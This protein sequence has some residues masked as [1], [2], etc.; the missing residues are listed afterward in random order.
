M[1][2]PEIYYLHHDVVFLAKDL[3]GKYLF[4]K[5]DGQLCGGIITET[6]AYKGMEDKACHAFGGRRTPRNEMMYARGGVAYVY[7]CYGIHPLLNVVVNQK[8]TPDAILIRAIHATHGEELMLKRTGKPQMKSQVTDGPGKV[9]KAL[10]ITL[11]DNGESF[12]NKRIWIEDRG[13]DLSK[14]EILN[15]PRIGID[16]AGEDAFLP[17]R[18]K[19]FEP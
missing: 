4:T 16:Y 18:F 5:I 15:T 11:A 13:F 7:L 8:D 19:I 14:I 17:Y 10:G 3:I 2:L 6:E 12:Q 9:T 1:L